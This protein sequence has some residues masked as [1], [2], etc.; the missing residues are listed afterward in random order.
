MSR[1]APPPAFLG[2]LNHLVSWP[3]RSHAKAFS[4][5]TRRPILPEH[6][7][8]RQREAVAIGHERGH[9][10]GLGGQGGELLG[11]REDVGR[12]L[13][14]QDGELGLEAGVHQLEADARGR[15][16]DHAVDG[17]ARLARRQHGRQR[18]ERGGAGVGRHAVA[19]LLDRIDHRHHLDPTIARLRRADVGVGNAAGPDDRDLEHLICHDDVTPQKT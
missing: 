12:G 17:E 5:R 6:G 7:G 19:V 11:V 3:G 13:F 10:L 14:H 8:H 16:D 15:A 4:K 1:N 9:L 18:L 2:S